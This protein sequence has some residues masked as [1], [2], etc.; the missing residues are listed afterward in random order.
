MLNI[1]N[2]IYCTLL[3]L[4]VSSADLSARQQAQISK[5]QAV[6]LVKSNYPGKIVKIQNGRQ[7]YKIRVLQKSGRVITLKVDKTTG[8]IKR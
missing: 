5:Q 6:K 3:C 7:Y 1:R 2:L 4:S 8:K